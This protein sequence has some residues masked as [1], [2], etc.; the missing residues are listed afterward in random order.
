VLRFFDAIEL[1]ASHIY[2]SALPLSPSSSV[3]R[4]RYL[5]QESTNVNFNVID[6]AWDSCIRT[7][8]SQ[9]V[10]NSAVFSHKDD[11][12][13]VGEWGIVE[14]F[15]AATGQRRATLITNYPVG[16]LAFSPN[17]TILASGQW[18]S[19]D[20]RVDV[21]DLQTGGHIGTLK[22]HNKDINSIEFSPC[23]NMIATCSDDCTVRIWNTFPLDC[24]YILEGHSKRI[25]DVCW[26]ASGS[27]IISGSED[28]T[29]KV[30]SVSDQQCS[31]TLTIQTGGP[32]YSLATSPD[33]SL[34]AARSNDGI[35]KLYDAE[36]GHVFH[37]I[38]VNVEY[39]SLIRFL[40][41]DYI[42]CLANDH[43][44]G[45]F[46]IFDLTTN[47]GL[48]TFECGGRGRA[49]S[50]DGTRVVSEQYHVVK[51]WQIDT[52]T[53]NQDVAQDTLI[54][55]EHHR[56]KGVKKMLKK[57]KSV[58]TFAHHKNHVETSQESQATSRHT[59]AVHC[60][61]FSEDGQL[62]A[63]GSEDK[64][65]KVWDTSTGQCLTT[66]CGHR[67]SVHRVT[68]SPDSKLCASFGWD[69]VV[70]IWKVRT[71]KRVSTFD[72]HNW[73]DDMRDIS[74]SLDGTQLVSLSQVRVEL[75]NVATGDCLASMKVELDKFTDI[76]FGVDGSSIILR[77][78]D[79]AIQRWTLSSVHNPT[80][81]HINNLTTSLPRLPMYF[82]PIQDMDQPTTLPDIFLHQYHCDE[83]RSWILDN[84]SRQMLWI[85]PDLKGYCHG[86]NVAFVS[87]SGGVTIGHFSNAGTVRHSVM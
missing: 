1:S 59:G 33:S 55:D 34:V 52:A 47:V 12:V 25:S 66:F 67:G 83:R 21:W 75:W 36:S 84:Q 32:V 17:D 10:T 7:I 28:K 5:N 70:Q 23:G 49:M 50:S 35:V 11:L 81:T 31:Q 51:I 61:T 9:S 16:S 65:V 80:V 6:D 37:T 20:G 24:R 44:G 46:G 76:S 2:E 13:A 3:V 87:S 53:Q 82:L 15:E 19:I 73:L 86:E 79:D 58:F 72:C 14:I 41:R 57:M 29:I 68:L 69:G 77:D 85:P 30:W 8:R 48:L 78:R 22:G 4:A 63:S 43:E 71:G 26:S 27:T 39:I 38:L 56:T 42:M 40:N 54:Q 18:D 74:F 62:V 60:V 45:K 64:T